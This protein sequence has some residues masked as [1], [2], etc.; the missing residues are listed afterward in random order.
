MI[1][2]IPYSHFTNVEQIAKGGF[3][4]IYRATWSI[5]TV[6]IKKYENSQG[7]NKYFLNEVNIFINYI[8][9]HTFYYDGPIFK[10]FKF[11]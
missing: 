11:N 8:F 9:L 7:I 3:G 1:G 4:T 10:I 5:K 2:W 6:I